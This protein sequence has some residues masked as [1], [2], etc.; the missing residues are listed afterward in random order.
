VQGELQKLMMH[1][2]YEIPDLN[3]KRRTSKKID[4]TLCLSVYTDK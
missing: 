1:G 3:K 4:F 2:S